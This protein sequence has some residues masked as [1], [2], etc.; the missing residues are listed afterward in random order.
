MQRAGVES[1]LGIRKEGDRLRVDPSIPKTW[2]EFDVTLRHGASRYDIHVENP[3]GVERGV[4]S[5]SLD[6]DDIRGAPLSL[7]LVDDGATRRLV[8]RLG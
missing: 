5:A 1:I 4:M 2:T 7:P 8:V 6:G 3:E